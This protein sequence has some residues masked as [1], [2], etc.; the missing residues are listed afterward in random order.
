MNYIIMDFIDYRVDHKLLHYQAI[1]IC[2]HPIVKAIY[3]GT[4][5]SI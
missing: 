2:S 1:D 4:M 5:L 3:P